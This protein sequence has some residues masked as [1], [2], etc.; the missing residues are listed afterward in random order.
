MFPSYKQDTE[1]DGNIISNYFSVGTG[2]LCPINMN[3]GIQMVGGR[4]YV[5]IIEWTYR[6]FHVTFKSHLFLNSN[7]YK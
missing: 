4:K 6:D 2:I 5:E 7:L 3:K 1:C